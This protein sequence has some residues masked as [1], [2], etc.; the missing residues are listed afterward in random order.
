LEMRTNV[1]NGFS[2]GGASFAWE[3]DADKSL[4]LSCAPKLARSVSYC[5]VEGRIED[6]GDLSALKFKKL[7]DKGESQSVEVPGGYTIVLLLDDYYLALE[8]LR[9]APNGRI[10]GKE[11]SAV[12]YQRQFWPIKSV[13][14]TQQKADLAK[15]TSAE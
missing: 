2:F 7:A 5:L 14:S 6:A 9:L 12:W 13:K 1:G 11:I 3:T 8:P 10:A 15:A 4:T